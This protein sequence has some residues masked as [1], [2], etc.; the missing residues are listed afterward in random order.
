MDREEVL[1]HYKWISKNITEVSANDALSAAVEITK[2]EAMYEIARQLELVGSA[3]YAFYVNLVNH[4][5][6]PVSIKVE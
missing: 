5:N 2:M 6:N 1:K 4:P 3:D